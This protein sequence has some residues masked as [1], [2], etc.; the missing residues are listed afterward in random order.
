MSEWSPSDTITVVAI[1]VAALTVLVNWYT[2]WRSRNTAE[3]RSER[4]RHLQRR[5]DFVERAAPTLREIRS[6]F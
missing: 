2:T 3:I 1:G 4:N 6:I 5:D